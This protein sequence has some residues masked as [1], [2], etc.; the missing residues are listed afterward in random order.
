V[1]Q[2]LNNPQSAICNQREIN[3][4]EIPQSAIRNPQLIAALQRVSGAAWQAGQCRRC[5]GEA[6]ER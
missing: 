3:G 6:A 2:T 5:T 4:T 1:S